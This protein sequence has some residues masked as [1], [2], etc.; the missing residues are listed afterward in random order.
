MDDLKSASSLLQHEAE[1]EAAKDRLLEK[2]QV[3]PSV[4]LAAVSTSIDHLQVFVL[5]GRLEGSL[6]TNSMP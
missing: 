5:C 1:E 3:S 4:T 6:R 2:K